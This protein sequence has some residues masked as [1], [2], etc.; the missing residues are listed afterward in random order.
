MVSHFYKIDVVVIT[1]GY[2]AG[3]SDEELNI[4]EE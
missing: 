4:I 1:E 3:W 2:I